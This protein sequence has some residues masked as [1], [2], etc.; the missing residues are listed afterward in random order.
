MTVLEEIRQAV[1]IDDASI[2]S[3]MLRDLIDTHRSG[4]GKEAKSLSD[5]YEQRGLPIQTRRS[6]NPNKVDERVPN[7]FFAYIVD[8]KTGYMGNEVTV[9]LNREAYGDESSFTA[10]ES[11]LSA[12]L[13][14]T[15]AVDE[16]SEMVKE[17]AKVGRGY[18]MLY[19][20]AGRTEVR[21]RLV[22]EHEGFIVVD[23]SLDEPV[24]F[25]RYWQVADHEYDK[26]MRT[27][28]K[29]K[30]TV[31]EWYDSRMITYY[32]SDKQ[33]QKYALDVSKGVGGVQEHGFDGV[34]VIEFPNNA[35]HQAE[36][37][38]VIALIDAY[39]TV[40]SATVSEIEQLRL[41][42]LAY[43][44]GEKVD[45]ELLELLK[46]TG[47]MPLSPDGDA[48]FLKK[49]LAIE[50]V[51]RMLDKIR[52]NIILFSG[53]V[54]VDMANF[55]GDLRV[56]G[57]QVALLNLENSSKVTERKFRKALMRQYE[58]ITDKWRTWGMADIDPE[59]LT[60]TFTRNFPKDLAG[61]ATT[62][63]DLLG[64]VSRKTAYGLMSFIDDPEAE[65][66]AIEAEGPSME[67]FSA[68]AGP[69]AEPEISN[70]AR[71]AQ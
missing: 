10:H 14:R 49:E 38:K 3:A 58:L 41:A 4:E 65:I 62:L 9:A 15:F 52:D 37:G 32:I 18:R 12:H 50:G 22:P 23:E 24:Y 8:T 51:E 56:I 30:R 45:N 59:N 33:G 39:D 69:G 28:S 46:Q 29:S 19:I 26:G 20:P 67:L 54:S 53:S 60:F 16:N 66:E 31:V 68:D 27:M 44:G 57:W 42:Y 21:Q 61:E 71:D 11:V 17:A 64:A 70:A 43:K 25:V 47:I 2:T 1:E 48:Y 55:G 36:A 35:E 40:M 34:P 7:D 5:R 63:L 13:R 6:P